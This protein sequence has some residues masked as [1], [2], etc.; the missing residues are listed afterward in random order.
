MIAATPPTPIARYV[1]YGVSAA[2]AAA[3]MSASMAL[4]SASEI[5]SAPCAEFRAVLPTAEIVSLPHF[6]TPRTSSMISR[7]ASSPNLPIGP[8]CF[9]RNRA[10]P[11]SYY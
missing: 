10:S 1:K 11:T 8:G 3:L 6:A 5:F 9:L 4:G 7:L 2:S